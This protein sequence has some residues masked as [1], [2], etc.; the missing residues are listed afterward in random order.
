MIKLE[1]QE[2]CCGCKACA[3]KCPKKCIS[4]VI[5]KEG[6]WYPHVDEELCVDC[7]LCEKVCP[8]LNLGDS[9]SPS[10]VYA[11]KHP[12]KETQLKSSSGGAFSLLAEMV[13]AKGGVVFGA[14]FNAHWEVVHEKAETV[15]QLERLRM[16]KYVQSDIGTTFVEAQHELKKGR[17]V[18]F[19]GTPCQIKGFKLF[20]QKD[21]SNL[22]LVDF[23]CHGVPSPKV[24]LR[25][26]D[27]TVAE[28]DKNTVLSSSNHSSSKRDAS[29]GGIAFRDKTLGWE[30][31]SFVLRKNIAEP[32]GD[33]DKI[34]FCPPLNNSIMVSEPLNKNPY[35]RGFIH[36]LYLR[37]S[38]YECRSKQFR[39]G[40]DLTL[41]DFWGIKQT[42]PN[43]FDDNGVSVVT[44]NSARGEELLRESKASITEVEY[45]K[46]KQYNH[47]FE[48]SVS[49]PPFRW[50]FFALH[51]KVKMRHLVLLVQALNKFH[52][53]IF[54]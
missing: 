2:D 37:P 30:K 13:I 6:F 11:L 48:H 44:V 27:E 34:Q 36:D 20:L 32:S 19:V 49:R 50:T 46:V 33:G 54:K 39:S 8:Q 35:L 5:D 10:H 4:W 21:Y 22:Y 18:L 38:C 9:S 14:A 17:I 51:G 40:S 23:V 25:Y 3:Q 53:I 31:F 28:G 15:E 29:I 1:R 26:L 47:S 12:S 43:L 45:D 16:S 42:Y 24:W 52:R 7:G 41:G